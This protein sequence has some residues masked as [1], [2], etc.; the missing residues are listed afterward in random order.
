MLLHVVNMWLSRNTLFI[1]FGFISS[2]VVMMRYSSI[3]QT[4]KVS[5]FSRRK[6]GLSFSLFTTVG[7]Q[8]QFLWK[9]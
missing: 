9:I 7:H 6:K 2:T 5:V 1:F 4:K 3:T 8:S